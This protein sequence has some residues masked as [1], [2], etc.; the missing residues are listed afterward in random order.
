MS[1]ANVRELKRRPAR[2]PAARTVEVGIAEGDFEG[3]RCTAKVDFPARHLAALQ[4]R[5][6]G[7]FLEVMDAI[8]VDHNFPNDRDELAESMADVDPYA[9]LVA[10]ASAI[11]DAIG[12][13]PPR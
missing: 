13:L 11:F 1:A 2:R 12:A 9:G 8:I 4:S 10:M 3:W 6:A 7:A 5:D